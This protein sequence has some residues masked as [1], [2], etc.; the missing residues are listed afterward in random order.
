[1]VDNVLIQIPRD[2][3]ELVLRNSVMDFLKFLPASGFPQS[4]CGTGWLIC[5]VRKL[6]AD[7]RACQVKKIVVVTES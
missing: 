2:F 7:V 4:F 5:L 1:M 6:L 3:E